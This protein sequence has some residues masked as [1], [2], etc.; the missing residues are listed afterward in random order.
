M[1]QVLE[2][3]IILHVLQIKILVTHSAPARRQI[4]KFLCDRILK[5]EWFLSRRTGLGFGVGFVYALIILS[6]Q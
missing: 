3:F 4:R 2:M 6:L 1:I 5:T